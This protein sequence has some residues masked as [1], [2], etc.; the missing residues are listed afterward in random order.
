MLA[1][2]A[3][4]VIAETMTGVTNSYGELAVAANMIRRYRGTPLWDWPLPAWATASEY[5]T[6]IVELPGLTLPRSGGPV[7]LADLRGYV[8]D[9]V[10]YTNAAPWPLLAGAAM[11]VIDPLADNSTGTAWRASVIVGT[12]GTFNTAML[13]RDSD[14]MPDAW[15]QQIVTANPGDAL[16]NSAS[17]LPGADYD[18]DGVANA[19]EYVAGTSPTTNDAA[20]ILMWIERV[21]PGVRVDFD[22]IAATGSAYD[23]Y[24]ARLYD[25]EGSTN[26]LALPAWSGIHNYTNLVGSG[27][28]VIFTNTT[29]GT[30]GFYRYGIRLQPRR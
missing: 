24:S 17:V 4:L 7:E 9:R 5:A 28:T 20:A 16:T 12:P 3:Y 30:N 21:A 19:I 14:G 29:P 25:L 15:E 27:Q 6:R 1:T 18:H 2:N 11:E 13:D 26:L 23:L 10:P 22:T 8:I